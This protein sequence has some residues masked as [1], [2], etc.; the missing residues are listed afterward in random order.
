MLPFGRSI[1][2]QRTARDGMERIRIDKIDERS[3]KYTSKHAPILAMRYGN[4]ES[5]VSRLTR[6]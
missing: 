5:E 1:L 2:I 3:W 6:D 4:Q